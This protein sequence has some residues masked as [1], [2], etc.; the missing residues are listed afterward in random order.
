MTQDQLPQA[1]QAMLQALQAGQAD[2]AR[3]QASAIL[4]AVPG[5]PNAAQVLALAL[6]REG[7]AAEALPHLQAANE[8]APSHPPI[9]NMLGAAQKQL[10]QMDE[11]RAAFEGALAADAN[12]ADAR[13]NLAQLDLDEMHTGSA[14]QHFDAVL[15]R[16]PQNVT[17]LAGRARAALLAQDNE[18]A[19]DFAQAALARQP[20]HILAG[21]TLAVARLRL[22]DFG[23]ALA[24]AEPIAAR[25][26][27]GDVNR[28]YA[29]GFAADANDRLGHY[30]E[31][32]ALYTQAN[33]LQ[34]DHFIRFKILDNSPFYPANVEAMASHLDG[35]NLTPPPCDADEPMPVFLVGF[36]RSGTT[37]LEQILMSHPQI[38]S[39]GEHAALANTCLDLYAG[40]GALAR[41]D[42]LD[43]AGTAARR[44]TYWAEVAKQGTL[45]PGHTLLD[46]L[47]LN[48]I[49][50]PAVAKIFPRAKIIFALRDP[51][52]VVLSCV[53]QRFGMNAAMYQFLSLET[54]TRYYDQVMTLGE[55]TR[56]RYAFEVRVVRYDDVIADLEGE[57]RATIEFIG[58]PWDD[59]VLA[60]REQLQ[61][62]AIDT[63]S[64]SQ[65]N[66]PIYTRAIGKWRHYEAH[67]A[68]VRDLLDKWAAHFHYD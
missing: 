36:P 3:T 62:R 52:D 20:A 17:A 33:D 51:R 22:K 55:K 25:E 29:L 58:L 32:Y 6:L 13:L 7:K 9:L 59:A 67:L 63:P 47:P 49:F 61:A 53:Q 28:A 56:E 68:G 54:A 15:T 50:L 30:D 44:K 5:E 46:K 64:V 12:F 26:D 60:Y 27:A 40:D 16:Q 21:L 18:A 39:F 48:T 10:G 34:A 11:A 41:F 37:L 19:R 57:A 4:R 2:A 14:A 24:V 31:A 8:T 43:E 42:A 35:A 1:V 66:E 45:A 65:V 23:G 38:E